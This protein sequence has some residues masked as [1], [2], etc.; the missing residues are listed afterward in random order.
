MPQKST[1]GIAIT[2]SK[3]GRRCVE[4]FKREAAVLAST[5]GVKQGELFEASGRTYGSPRLMVA[6]RRTGA[7]YGHRRVARFIRRAGLRARLLISKAR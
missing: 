3:R 1:T 4:E 6:L 7:R 2:Q 5:P